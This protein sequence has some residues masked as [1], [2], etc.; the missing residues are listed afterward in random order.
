MLPRAI[1]FFKLAIQYGKDQRLP[2]RQKKR[3][4]TEFVFEIR[5]IEDY[6]FLEAFVVLRRF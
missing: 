4:V 2:K 6:A 5:R 3:G 1:F